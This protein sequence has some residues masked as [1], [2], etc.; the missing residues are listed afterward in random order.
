MTPLPHSPDRRRF[1]Q[2]GAAAALGLASGTRLAAAD[3]D[4][5]FGG[6]TLGVQTYT[7]RRFDLEPCLKRIK[8]LGLHGAEF[9]Q[10]LK[11][12]PHVPADSSPDQI[13][14]VLKLCKEYDVTPTAWGVQHFSKDTDAN[15]KSF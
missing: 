6:F 7:F 4:D 9:F 1:L 8:D 11:E 3:K 15:R 2:A 14:A 13:K 5:P 10:G 12:H